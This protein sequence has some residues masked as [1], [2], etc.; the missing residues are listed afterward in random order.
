MPGLKLDLT[1]MTGTGSGESTM[2][3]GKLLPLTATA[4]LHSETDLSMNMAGQKQAISTKLD[5]NVRLESK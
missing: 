1:K 4:D 2:D 5:A 3:L